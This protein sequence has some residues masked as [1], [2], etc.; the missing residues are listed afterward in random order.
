[1]NDPLNELRSKVAATVFRVVNPPRTGYQP[2]K[3]PWRVEG[4]GGSC[5]SVRATEREALLK[6]IDC[7]KQLRGGR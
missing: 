2:K 5:W 3:Y 6:A 4:P 1:M 7:A